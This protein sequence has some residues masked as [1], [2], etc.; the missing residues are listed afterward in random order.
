MGQDIVERLSVTRT[1][2]EAA[3]S[4]GPAVVAVTSARGTDGTNLLAH[5]LAQSLAA[6]GRG[7]LLVRS[8]PK[9]A[10]VEN[11][12]RSIRVGKSGEP[13]LLD[14]V[15][16][17]SFEAAQAAFAE[18]RQ[19]YAFTIVDAALPLRS[20]SALSLVGA[21]DLVLIAVEQGRAS[22]EEDKELAGALRSARAKTLGVV[23]IDRKEIR[24]FADRPPE[25]KVPVRPARVDIDLL[26]DPFDEPVG[27]G[28]PVASRLG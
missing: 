7:V 24:R 25:T 23:T 1:R 16:S 14:L 18:F 8:D 21:A 26:F 28:A 22:R 10:V 4:G 9:P 19:R 13:S 27:R 2:I 6:V 5:G 17:Y 3:A 12:W 11:R 20:G 15:D